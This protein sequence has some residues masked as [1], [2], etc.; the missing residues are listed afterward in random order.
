MQR[1]FGKKLDWR[2]KAIAFAEKT[3]C[4]LNRPPVWLYLAPKNALALT[5]PCRQQVTKLKYYLKR[6]SMPFKNCFIFDILEL[7]RLFYKGLGAIL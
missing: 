7:A 2:Q 1:K 6:H 5:Y 3:L 4:S